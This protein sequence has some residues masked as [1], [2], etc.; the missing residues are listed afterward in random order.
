MLS[1]WPHES[2]TSSAFPGKCRSLASRDVTFLR[3]ITCR[4]HYPSLELYLHFWFRIFQGLPAES[5][6]IENLKNEQPPRLTI[7]VHF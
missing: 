2:L 6:C 3:N 5:K 4:S 7:R 1:G